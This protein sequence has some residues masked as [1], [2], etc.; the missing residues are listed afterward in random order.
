MS[1]APGGTLAMA[2]EF[3]DSHKKQARL[4]R[5]GRKRA[6]PIHTR[7]VVNGCTADATVPALPGRPR[8]PSSPS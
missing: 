2:G 8:T 4:N 6:V 5:P 3:W 1:I 7:T